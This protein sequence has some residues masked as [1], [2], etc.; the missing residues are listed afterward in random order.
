MNKYPIWDI[1]MR[2]KAHPEILTEREMAVFI[3]LLVRTAN[4]VM[5]KEEESST[6]GR[7]QLIEAFEKPIA[8]SKKIIRSKG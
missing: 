6:E 7:R 4:H 2:A 3:N 8:E 5:K 1:D